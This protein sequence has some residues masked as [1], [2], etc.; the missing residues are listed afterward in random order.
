[1]TSIDWPL[2]LMCLAGSIAGGLV[3]FHGVAAYY[4][5]RYYVLRRDEP[6][7]WKC[8]PKR[9][10]RPEQQRN[11]ALLS[12]F[13][14]AMGGTITGFL[15][16]A[17]SQGWQTPLYFD[18][19]KYGWPYAIGSGIFMFV[20]NDAGAYYVHRFLHRKWMY[21]NIHRHHHSWV[22]TSPYVTS[23]VH[24]LELLLLQ[25]NTFLPLFIIPFHYGVVIVVLIYILVFNI[26]DHSGVRLTSAMPWQ[27]PSMY[28]DDH[29]AHFH[30]NFG[31]HLMIWDKFHGTLRRKKRKYGVKVFGGRGEKDVAGAAEQDEFF[32]Y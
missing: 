17:L 24:P 4:H 5:I 16:Y 12:S 32:P 6:E 19:D 29:H 10:L 25:G 28:H 14:L 1:M 20:L 22:A 8:Q 9:F 23:A 27:G 11:A 21:K 18:I 2:L 26:I 7:T 31:Q 30:C 15:V 3:I 13:N